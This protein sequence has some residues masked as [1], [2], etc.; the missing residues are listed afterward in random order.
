MHYKIMP[1]KK[2][3]TKN[4]Q[5]NSNEHIHYGGP[6]KKVFHYFQDLTTNNKK[7]LCI[8]QYLTKIFFNQLIPFAP[9]VKRG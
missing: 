8:N 2:H 5:T 3:K 7:K 1:L 4:K 9:S 6:V